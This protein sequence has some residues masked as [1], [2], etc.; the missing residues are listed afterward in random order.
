MELKTYLAEDN[1]VLRENLAGA[2]SELTCVKVVGACGTEKESLSWLAD[3]PLN[4]DL[5][6]VDLFLS[7]GSGIRLVE[8]VRRAKASQKIIVLSNYVNA[9]VRMTCA[10]LGVDAVFD[11]STEVDELVDYCSRQCFE[12]IAAA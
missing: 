10:R 7:P 3:N 5:L 4:W 11:K 1:A 2:L 9:A 12:Q 8:Q 6:V